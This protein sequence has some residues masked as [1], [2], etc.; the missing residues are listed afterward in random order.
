MQHFSQIAETKTPC[1]HSVCHNPASRSPSLVCKR[2]KTSSRATESQNRTTWH[3]RWN[4]QPNV[5]STLCALSRRKLS[6]S[7]LLEWPKASLSVQSSLRS[8]TKMSFSIRLLRMFMFKSYLRSSFQNPFPRSS[9]MRTPTRHAPFTQDP[10][11]TVTLDFTDNHDRTQ[12][13]IY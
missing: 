7:T 12:R 3:F 4:F 6:F 1:S 9:D 11:F 5:F 13:L 8:S 2:L 10:L